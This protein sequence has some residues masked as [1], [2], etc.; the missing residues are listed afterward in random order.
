MSMFCG[1]QT[2]KFRVTSKPDGANVEIYNHKTDSYEVVGKTPFENTDQKISIP[3]SLLKSDLITIR[4]SQ[5]GFI[6]EQ[7]LLEKSGRPEMK[8]HAN[9]KSVK[10]GY[11]EK[12]DLS[13]E[14]NIVNEIAKVVVD[15]Q[16]LIEEKK[17]PKAIEKITALVGEFPNSY[18]L[19]DLKGS[20]HYVNGEKG[21]AISSYEKSVELNP[22]NLDTKIILK[23]LGVK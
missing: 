16:T 13:R 12:E 1:C 11:D 7:V 3:V 15:I 10:S 6:S 21:T 20:L 5:P 23:K 4:I 19:W 17:I 18:Y 9:L 22:N 2:S 8:I 14:Q